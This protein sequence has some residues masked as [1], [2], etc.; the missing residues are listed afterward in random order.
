MREQD[1]RDVSR[2]I[3][4]ALALTTRKRRESV[5]GDEEAF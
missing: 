3:S 5:S 4:A 2:T 1:E